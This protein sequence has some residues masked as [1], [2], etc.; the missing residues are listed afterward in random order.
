MRRS[1]TRSPYL[2]GRE[3][4]WWPWTTVEKAYPEPTRASPCIGGSAGAAGLLSVA[5][6]PAGGASTNTDTVANPS[7]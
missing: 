3:S 6:V 4:I 7:D 5:G 2:C 1:M